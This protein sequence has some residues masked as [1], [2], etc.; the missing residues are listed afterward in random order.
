MNIISKN[1]QIFYSQLEQMFADRELEN[2]KGKNDFANLLSIKSK[3][4]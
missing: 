2:F 3:Y 4:I 1:K